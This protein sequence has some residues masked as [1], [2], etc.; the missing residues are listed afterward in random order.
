[1][2]LLPFRLSAEGVLTETMRHA[3]VQ[4]VCGD[5]LGS[6]VVTDASKGFIF[7]V[8]H[9]PI[10]PE[11]GEQVARC[12]VGF[13]TGTGTVPNSFY[14]ADVVHAVLSSKYDLD[15]AV[16]KRTTRFSGPAVTPSEIPVNLF[17]DKGESELVV[18]YPRSSENGLTTSSGT[19]RGFSRGTIDGSAVISEGYSGGPGFDKDGNLMG[20]ASRVT[21]L[22][23]PDTDEEK[24]YAYLLGD[25]ATMISWL[26]A[27]SDES[28][29]A[30]MSH[31]D[32][33]RFSSLPYFLRDEGSGCLDVVRTEDS[34]AVYC[35]LAEDR[36]FVFPDVGVFN[37][38]YTNFDDVTW[39]Y[40][41]DIARFQL[42]GN[43]TYKAGSLIKIISDST[44]YLVTDSFGTLRPI[45]SEAR[46][47]ELF[48]A[49][50]SSMVKDVADTFFIDYTVGRF[51]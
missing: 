49:D 15:F 28:H 47:V 42:I 29:D 31:A 51:I 1:M 25:M 43:M 35:L 18:G 4:V 10:D 30:Y 6:G 7:T 17:V 9:V 12:Q 13:I 45:P 37:S 23:D 26:D 24:D 20:I 44:V 46:A 19:I 27:L 2:V 33:D 41:E 5:R 3:T 8:G 22:I 38:W 34:P 21:Y 14:F 32:A 40:R 39:V 11:T 48:G 16:L 36:R 50:W